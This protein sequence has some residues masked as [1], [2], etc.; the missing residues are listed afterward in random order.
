MMCGFCFFVFKLMFLGVEFVYYY[1]LVGLFIL[2]LDFFVVII[3]KVCCDVFINN[4]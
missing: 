2:I 3:M 1:C 4:M